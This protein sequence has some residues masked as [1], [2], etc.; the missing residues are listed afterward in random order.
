MMVFENMMKLSVNATTKKFDKAKI[1]QA[2]VNSIVNDPC[3][4]GC[5]PEPCTT[6]PFAS[7]QKPTLIGA[8]TEFVT[9]ACSIETIIHHP[10]LLQESSTE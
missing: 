8:C 2:S 10:R 3:A 7:K 4:Y 5:S 9:P 1:T 6:K